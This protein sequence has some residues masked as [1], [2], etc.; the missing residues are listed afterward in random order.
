[1]KSN[2][3]IRLY[4]FGE[5][6]GREIHRIELFNSDGYSLE[7]L[8]LGAI[9]HAFSVNRPGER[10][11][12]V[13]VKPTVLEGYLDNPSGPDYCFGASIGRYAGRIGGG[14]FD[15]G[16]RRFE[17]PSENGVHLHGGPDGLGKKVWEL[18]GSGGGDRPWILLHAQSPDGEGG[19]PGQIDAYCRYELVGS[20]CVLT[21]YASTDRETVLNMTNHAYFNLSDHGDIRGQELRLNSHLW[22]DV[23]ER[24]LPTG[25][26]TELSDSPLDFRPG[27]S[28]RTAI[29]Y[30]GFLDN[31]FVLD[32]EPKRGRSAQ[33]TDPQNGLLLTIHTNQPAVVVFTP[34]RLDHS[35]PLSSDVREYPAICFETQNYPD[36]PNR[37][38]FPSSLLRP[39]STYFSRTYYDLRYRL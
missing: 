26:F 30:H 4:S 13:I 28:L 17:L 2:H 12:D 5:A 31:A 35:G 7:V 39:G 33:L 21:Y 27:R 29:E 6:W 16:G 22:L 34:E 37:R 14:G 8:T 18:V 38:H 32:W 1:M 20:C 36:A 9:W 23:D 24:N 10:R 25:S 19:Y 11:L 15:L 3:Q